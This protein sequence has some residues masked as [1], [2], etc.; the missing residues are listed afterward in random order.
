MYINKTNGRH[1]H[2]RATQERQTSLLTKGYLSLKAPI[3]QNVSLQ[4]LQSDVCLKHMTESKAHYQLNNFLIR[5]IKVGF[6]KRT[7]ILE[8]NE[9]NNLTREEL[10]IRV[11]T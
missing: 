3:K 8:K 5:V 7:G 4:V 2:K 1:T 10:L 9:K 11:N 6:K